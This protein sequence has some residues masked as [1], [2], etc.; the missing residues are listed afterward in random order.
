MF[1]PTLLIVTP[2]FL[3]PGWKKPCPILS[4][5]QPLADQLLLTRQRINGEHC[6]HKLETGDI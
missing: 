1:P 5:A 3:S 6:L 4:S 2:L